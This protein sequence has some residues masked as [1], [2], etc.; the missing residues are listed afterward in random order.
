MNYTKHGFFCCCDGCRF[1][2]RSSLFNIA[3]ILIFTIIV[4]YQAFVN[5]FIH[6]PANGILLFIELCILFYFI[7]RIII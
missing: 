7:S 1:K 2:R 3:M 6:H 5:I 4:L